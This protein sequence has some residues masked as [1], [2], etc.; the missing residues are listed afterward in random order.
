MKAKKKVWS[1]KG[2][3]EL[4]TLVVDGARGVGF[5]LSVMRFTLVLLD[6]SP[7]LPVAHSCFAVMT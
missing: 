2:N 3:L 1:Q 7:V 5:K 6:L 4:N